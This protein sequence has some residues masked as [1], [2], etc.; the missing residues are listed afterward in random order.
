MVNFSYLCALPTL[1]SIEETNTHDPNHLQ[2]QHTMQNDAA[3]GNL[4][5][6]LCALNSIRYPSVND[7]NALLYHYLKSSSRH[8]IVL[9][10]LVQ[11]YFGMKRLGPY[12]NA[13]TFNILLDGMTSTGNLRAAFFFC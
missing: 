5:K 4:R 8:L 1:D 3:P 2:L 9:D 12:P 7:Y 11:V 10:E 6:S 13:S